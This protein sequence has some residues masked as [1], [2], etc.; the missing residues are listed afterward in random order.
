MRFSICASLA[1]FAIMIPQ[2]SH[3]QESRIVVAEPGIEELSQ[4]QRAVSRAALIH[5]WNRSRDYV[6]PSLMYEAARLARNGHTKN[7]MTDRVTTLRTQF[8]ANVS[9]GH[10]RTWE[11]DQNY[12][13]FARH[14]GAVAGSA[15]GKYAPLPGLD[16]LPNVV[17]DLGILGYES[18][19]RDNRV[20]QAAERVGANYYNVSAAEEHIAEY[21]LDT[22]QDLEAFRGVFREQFAPIVFFEPADHPDTILRRIPTLA[23]DES[24]QEMHTFLSTHDFVTPE[25]VTKLQDN[26]GKMLS[27]LRRNRGKEARSQEDDSRRAIRRQAIRSAVFLATTTIGFTDPELAQRVQAVANA[28]IEIGEAIETYKKALEL[29]EDLSGSASLIMTADFVGIALTVAAAFLDQGP[30]PEQIILEELRALRKEVADM[31]REMHG[32]F[33]ILERHL[34]EMLDRLDRGFNDLHIALRD[35]NTTLMSIKARLDTIQTEL[36]GVDASVARQ[37]DRLVEHTK[38]LR[39]LHCPDWREDA[40]GEKIG[41]PDYWRCLSALRRSV[42]L[43]HLEQFA[44]GDEASSLH[45]PMFSESMRNR[46]D[47]NVQRSAW[48]LAQLAGVSGLEEFVPR[49]SLWVR[50]ANA[51]IKFVEDWPRH[52]DVLVSPTEPANASEMM[53]TLRLQDLR[54]GT[55]RVNTLVSLV[56]QE[57]RSFAE[58]TADS[59]IDNVLGRV[60]SRAGALDAA[61]ARLENEYLDKQV[62]EPRGLTLREV[63]IEPATDI[64]R[65]GFHSESARGY[66]GNGYVGKI[67]ANAETL[68]PGLVKQLARADVG[69]IEYCV[70]FFFDRRKETHS[71]HDS[72][73]PD[74]S[75]SLEDEWNWYNDYFPGPLT[76]TATLYYVFPGMSCGDGTGSVWLVKAIAQDSERTGGGSERTALVFPYHDYDDWRKVVAPR[77]EW[78]QAWANRL[79]Q[80]ATIV[81][82]DFAEECLHEQMTANLRRK[83]VTLQQELADEWVRKEIESDHGIIALDQDNEND[84]ALLSHWTWLGFGGLGGEEEV[85]DRLIDGSASGPTLRYS[86]SPSWAFETVPLKEAKQRYLAGVDVLEGVLRA[87]VSKRIFEQS[88]DTFGSQALSGRIERWWNWVVDTLEQ[89]SE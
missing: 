44:A 54:V 72:W 41:R 82:N 66:K 24:V 88:P 85:V 86:V 76:A 52:L 36:N 17:L 71:R 78:N 89:N 59:A 4:H 73:E 40:R 68:I 19:V 70:E 46:K 23:Q 32:R 1:A 42:E 11:V 79:V 81:E 25:D 13:L 10:N 75:T 28:T 53:E 2:H 62:T 3:A 58:G 63:P 49:P 65:C 74:P 38:E 30:S 50:D 22:W 21:V 83:W 45:S 5:Q 14:A 61:I 9:I 47:A 15:L 34:S 64:L 31:R 33:G 27:D 18:L 87:P 39:S 29:G 55:E 67:P 69:R 7:E 57:F 48:H 12:K 16:Q 43:E 60:R 84:Y 35:Q 51:Y 26:I 20:R 80:I 56:Q 77:E 37:T 6:T 8:E